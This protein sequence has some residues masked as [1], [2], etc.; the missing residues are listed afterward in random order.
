MK[1]GLVVH[2]L[3]DHGGHSLYAKVLADELSLHHE[4]TVFANRCERA[5]SAGWSFQPVRAWRVNAL[6]TVQTFPLGIKVHQASLDGFDIRHMQGYC[7]GQPNVVTAHICVAAYLDSLRSISARNRASLRLMAAAESGFY[8]RYE[9]HVIAISQKIARELRDFY[10]VRGEISVIPHGVDAARFAGLDREQ[11]GSSARTELGISS[12]A[13]VALYV[14]DLTKAHTHLKALAEAAPEVQFII[15]SRSAQYRWSMPNV[16]FLAP[17]P[18]LERYYAA[19]DALVFPT[20][21]DAFGMV[22]LEAMAS[23]LPVFTSDCAGAAELIDHGRDGFVFS[24]DDWAEATAAGLGDLDSL[25]TVGCE[26][27]KTAG[28]HDWSTVVRQVE[29]LYGTIAVA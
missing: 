6:A 1:I 12:E 18:E 2:D 26:A 15:V 7:G 28:R 10:Q 22:V 20:T 17:T 4:V 14:G 21:Y 13:T 16:R 8:R 5:V 25:R 24:L 19:A 3:H 11:R 29:E 27:E 23:A 9:G